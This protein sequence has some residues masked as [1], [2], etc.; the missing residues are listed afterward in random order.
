MKLVQGTAGIW[1]ARASEALRFTF[2]RT[3]GG[4]VLRNVAAHDA[5]LKEQ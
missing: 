2:Q 3:E 5:T 1:E 4:A